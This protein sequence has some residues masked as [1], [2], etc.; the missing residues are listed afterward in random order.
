MDEEFKSFLVTDPDILDEGIDVSGIRQATEQDKLIAGAIAEEPGLAY[1]PRLTS[2]LSDLNRYFSGGFPT[3]STPPTTTPTPP[4]N[5]G[6]GG[7]GG[8]DPGTDGGSG[9]RGRLTDSGTFGGQPTFTTTPGTTV[10]NITGD[11]TN[12]DGTYGGN[13]ID[14]VALTGRTTAPQTGFLASGA[15]GGASLANLD[16][17]NIDLGNPTGDSRV[18]SE[19]QGLV[20]TP[21]DVDPIMDPNLMSIRQQQNI[22][23]LTTPQSNTLRDIASKVGGDLT[24]FG[25][26]IASIPGAVYDSLSNTVEVFGEKFNIGKTAAG[27]VI[28]KLAG[29]PVSLLFPIVQKIASALPEQA[30]QTT[31]VDELKKEKDY[32]YNVTVGNLNVDPFGRNPVSGFGD[33]EKALTEDLVSTDPSPFTEAKKEFAQDY[34]N[35]KAEKAGGVEVEEGV[36]MGPGEALPEDGSLTTFQDLLDQRDKEREDALTDAISG[37]IGVEGEDEGRFTDR[38]MEDQSDGGG[39]G[40]GPPTGTNRPGGDRRDDSPAPSAPAPAAP[41]YQDAIM[42]G[43]TGGGSDPGGGKSIVCTAMYQTTGLEDWSKAMKIWYIYQKK[44]LTIQHQEGYHI[45][46]K[47]FVKGMHKS[48]IIKAIGAHVARHRTQHL[49]HIMFNSTPS[50][51]GKIYNKILE[52]ICYWVGKHG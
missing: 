16:L 1:D 45:L 22:E 36:V 40:D 10:D 33:Y 5:G 20:G 41:V 47:P 50:L 48:S 27:L 24:Q 6:G 43:Q 9:P 8:G 51:L 39:G 35:R 23:G 14:E 44:Y 11:I 28:N 37:D 26:E 3:I 13:L 42:R 29:G 7:D 19:E 25:K 32:G 38:G 52:P 30:I 34:F 46:F 4:T 21:P 18:V 12:P 15:A 17:D 31:I 49:K 2:Y